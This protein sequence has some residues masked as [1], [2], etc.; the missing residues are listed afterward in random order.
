MTSSTPT[1]ARSLRRRFLA[2]VSA[3]AMAAS[4]LATASCAQ[5]TGVED[6]AEPRRDVASRTAGGRVEAG[7][8]RTA[9]GAGAAETLG[10]PIDGTK[11]ESDGRTVRSECFAYRLPSGYEL[12]EKSRN[13][14]T[15][16]NS[17][18]GDSLT[19]VTIG[20]SSSPDTEEEWMDL[21]TSGDVGVLAASE[22]T[23]I[24]GFDA[25]TATV[26]VLYGLPMRFYV[27]FI[28]EGQFSLEGEP[29][30]SIAVFGYW[31]DAFSPVYE[32]ILDSLRINV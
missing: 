26:E 17:P 5:R 13:C 27:L 9:S 29:I 4:L 28:P 12:E 10:V 3:A 2:S 14:F 22:H 23:K 11:A 32:T 8:D 16:V 20:V 21:F 24:D 31:S 6:Q 1:G 19:A 30:T 15:V 18:S 7:G 25:I